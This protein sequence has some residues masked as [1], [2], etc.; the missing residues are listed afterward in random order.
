MP[1]YDLT[2]EELANLA[3]YMLSLDF[4]QNRK[5]AIDTKLVDGW[6]LLHLNNCLSCHK[7]NGVGQKT[8]HD[9][10]TEGA[11]RSMEWLNAYFQKPAEH[12][13]VAKSNTLA[14]LSSAEVDRLIKYLSTL[15]QPN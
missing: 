4:G 9:L 11:K 10:S 5:I 7:V 12:T 8:G 14:R 6:S 3:A 15:K 2:K 1:G 13:D